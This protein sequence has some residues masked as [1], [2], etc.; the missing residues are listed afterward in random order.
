MTDRAYNYQ[1]ETSPRKLKPEYEKLLIEHKVPQWYLNACKKIVYLFPKAH[2]TAYVLS[3]WRIAWFKVYY[4]KEYYSA[5]F[6]VR[7][8][9]FDAEYGLD[10]WIG[11]SSVKKS[12]GL[13]KGRSP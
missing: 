9:A 13:S 6:T 1:Y 2:A 8:D 3:A 7:A 4:P 11:V 10:V 12:S 5:Y